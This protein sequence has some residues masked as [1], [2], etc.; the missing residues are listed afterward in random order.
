MHR[1][2]CLALLAIAAFPALPALAADAPALLLAQVYRPGLPLQD[3][4]VSEKYDGVR[5]FWDGRTLRTRGGE[6]VQA[7]A[8]F[9]AGWPE[10][11][12]DGELWAG[13]GR[14]SHAQSTTRQQQPGDVAWRQIRFMVFDLPGDKG[15]FDQRLPALN[16]LVESLGQPWVQAVPQRRVA[17]DAALQALLHR[18]VRAGGEGLMLHRGASLYRA[19][20]SDDLIKVKTHEDTEARVVAHLPGKGRHA[21]RLGALLVETPSGQRFRLGAGF[22]DADRERP[23]PVGSWVTYRFRGTHDGGLPRFASFVREREDMPAK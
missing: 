12:M 10:V 1:R 4:W 18:T 17:N 21:G 3:Y 6:T 16:A 14:F 19:G 2:S 8:W 9:T 5:G 22:S 23:P 15:T 13:R 7:P 20:R 11:P